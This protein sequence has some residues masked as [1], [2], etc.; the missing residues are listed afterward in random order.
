MSVANNVGRVSLQREHHQIVHHRGVVGISQIDDRVIIIAPPN[1]IVAGFWLGDVDPIS[2][3]RGVDNPA[4]LVNTLY[5]D[6]VT[7]AEFDLTTLFIYSAGL[8][9]KPTSKWS[10]SPLIRSSDKAW[11]ESR[12]LEGTAEFNAEEDFPGPLPIAIALERSIRE[13]QHDSNKQQRVIVIGDG[14][15]L[16]NTY[17]QNAGNQEF[18]VR[19]VEWLVTDDDLVNVPSR[20]AEDITLLL[21]DWQKA[22]IG[23]GF[24]FVLPVA[25]A[26]NGILIWWRRRRA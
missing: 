18:G 11:S 14:D 19:L 15:F 12:A 7:V 13:P 1:H 3:A 6:H 5:G 9:A 21:T 17:L 22:V 8:V 20:I 25:F 26:A 24:L 23:I 10:S 4:M 16:S 2:L